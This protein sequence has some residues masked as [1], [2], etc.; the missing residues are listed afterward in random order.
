MLSIEFRMPPAARYPETA[1]DVNFGIRFL[2]ANAERFATRKELVGGLGTS[3]G[4]H[5]L[6]RVVVKE[7]ATAYHV[8]TS[9]KTSKVAK[10]WRQP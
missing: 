2:K 1:A 9:Y 4:G 3:S 10:Y 7:D 8:I 6:L 5:L